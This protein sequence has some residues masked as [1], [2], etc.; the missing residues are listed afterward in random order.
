MSDF[1]FILVRFQSIVHKLQEVRS[2]NQVIFHDNYFSIL[3]DSCRHG[4]DNIA[5]QSPILFPFD[6]C[7]GFESFYGMNE[8]S[9][10]V[11]FLRIQRIFGSIRIDIEVAFLGQC[12]LT[13][14]SHASLRVFQ[15][16]INEQ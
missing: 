12:I 5:S 4:V 9:Y 7:Y 1:W 14:G 6:N 2:Q 13:E 15:A 16:I 10:L 8:R 3:V 11:H